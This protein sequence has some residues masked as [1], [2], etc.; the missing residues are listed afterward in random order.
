MDSTQQTEV[1]LVISNLPDVESAE[2]LARA[3]IEQRLAACVNIMPACRSLYWWK[4]QIDQS[5]EIPVFF[6]T[7]RRS[8][9]DLQACIRAHHPYELPEVIAISVAD[10]LPAYLRWVDEQVEKP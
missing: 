5:G 1:L 8:F 4:G 2:L 3:V 9:T 7:T 6:K 10:G